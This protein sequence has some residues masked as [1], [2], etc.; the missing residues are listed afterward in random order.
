M[1]IFFVL[2]QQN[3]DVVWCRGTVEEKV[4][5]PWLELMKIKGLKFHDNKMVTDFM[6]N[7]DTGCISGVVC[8]REIY[9]ADAFILA[10]GVS[11]LKST[12]I[13]RYHLVDII[14]RKCQLPQF[15]LFFFILSLFVFQLGYHLALR[16]KLSS[17]APMS[18][19][20]K[21]C[22]S[23]FCLCANSNGAYRYNMQYIIISDL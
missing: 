23:N 13:S 8:G 22:N 11:T 17:E 20:C 14:L 6:V 2:V 10:V 12:V 3:F 15:N 19:S 21:A 7:E 5:L 1:F 9:E 16:G 4:F 18:C